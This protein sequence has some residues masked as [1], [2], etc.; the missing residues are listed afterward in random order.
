MNQLTPRCLLCGPI[1]VGTCPH[2]STELKPV[3]LTAEEH[4]A[5]FETMVLAHTTFKE[6][7]KKLEEIEQHL[8]EMLEY[9]KP[10]EGV[11]HVY[12]NAEKCLKKY[13]RLS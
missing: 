7:T 13:R 1:F 9:C 12:Y 3:G 5:L 2:G 4:K 6:Q 10:P 11:E 8:V